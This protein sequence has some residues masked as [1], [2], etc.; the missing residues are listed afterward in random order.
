MITTKELIEEVRLYPNICAD[1]IP[2]VV[3]ETE[4]AIRKVSKSRSQ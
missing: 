4:L 1:A 3:L 2:T